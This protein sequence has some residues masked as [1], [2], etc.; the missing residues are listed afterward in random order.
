MKM[1][2]ALVFVFIVTGCASTTQDPELRM[3][4]AAMGSGDAPL[5]EYYLED[6]IKNGGHGP[7]QETVA[8][9]AQVYWEQ[10]EDKKL[11]DLSEKYMPASDQQ[12]WWCRVLERRGH[13]KRAQECWSARGDDAK[14]MRAI[15]EQ[16]MLNQLAP[17][18]TGFGLRKD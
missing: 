6:M 11:L 5:A 4:K 18:K 12:L 15:R 17:P 7:T 1:F 10:G 14:A 16:A 2:A 8:T 3:A 9:L 13:F